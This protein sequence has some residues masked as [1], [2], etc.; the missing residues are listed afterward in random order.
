MASAQPLHR[1]RIIERENC[2]AV[3]QHSATRTALCLRPRVLFRPRAR[4]EWAGGG[5]WARPL[6]PH[7][8]AGLAGHVP[9]LL[10]ALA[11]L[12]LAE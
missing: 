7:G 5:V 9:G 12:L 2:A 8:L 1:M 11:V 4:A 10:Y 6:G 3:Q